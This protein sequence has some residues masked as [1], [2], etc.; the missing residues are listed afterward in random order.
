MASHTHVFNDDCNSDAGTPTSAEI[1]ERH[2]NSIS[3]VSAYIFSSDQGGENNWGLV[4]KLTSPSDWRDPQN[5]NLWQEAAVSSMA[6]S[7]GWA[8]MVFTG[9]ARL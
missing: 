7:S 2:N 9:A 5:N 1:D 8:V 4:K 3:N 6:R